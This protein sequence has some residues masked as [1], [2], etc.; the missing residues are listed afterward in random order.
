MYASI[1]R[2][3]RE[4]TELEIRRECAQ[5]LQTMLECPRRLVNIP[6]LVP[7]GFVEYPNQLVAKQIAQ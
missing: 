3:T 6:F 2:T 7:D 1:Q 4:T 5:V